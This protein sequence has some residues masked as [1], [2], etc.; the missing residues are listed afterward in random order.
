MLLL[1]H[2]QLQGSGVQ[3]NHQPLVRSGFSVFDYKRYYLCQQAKH[4]SRDLKATRVTSQLETS[5][6]K[7][8]FVFFRLLS[9]EVGPAGHALEEGRKMSGAF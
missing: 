8:R 7:R 2:G 1:G 3:G 5:S 4:F 6:V 9:P